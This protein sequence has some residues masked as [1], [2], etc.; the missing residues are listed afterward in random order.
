M[1]FDDLLSSSSL[2]SPGA[3]ALRDRTPDRETARALAVAAARG[4]GRVVRPVTYIEARTIGEAFGHGDVL[5]DMTHTPEDV[6]KRL[7]DFVAGL[8]FSYHAALERLGDRIFL[9]WD[10]DRVEQNSHPPQGPTAPLPSAVPEPSPTAQRQIDQLQH[11][12]ELNHAVIVEL[13]GQGVLDRDQIANLTVALNTA[14]RIGAAIGIIMA[15][16]TVTEDDAFA[17]LQRASQHLG[18]KLREVA[19]Q[20]LAAGTLTR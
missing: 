6:S 8:S 17:L 11:Q 20:V 3:R 15:T 12:A 16:Q 4:G 1:S 14:R 18:R 10:P 13:Q 7:V 9:L 2:G 19:E 5:I